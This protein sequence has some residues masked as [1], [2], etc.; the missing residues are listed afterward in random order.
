MRLVVKDTSVTQIRCRSL[1]PS[2]CETVDCYSTRTHLSIGTLN[3]AQP[4]MTSLAHA[5]TV[6]SSLGLLNVC[7]NIATC[8]SLLD[9]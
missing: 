9:T 1:I 5:S 7:I 8:S 3:R 4:S 2:I 6:V